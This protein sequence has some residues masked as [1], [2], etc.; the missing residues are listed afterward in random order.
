MQAMW[1]SKPE[2]DFS[3]FF[4]MDGTDEPPMTTEEMY[5]IILEHQKL[6][7]GS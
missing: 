3:R 7:N 6:S 2:K 4:P 5:N 1:S